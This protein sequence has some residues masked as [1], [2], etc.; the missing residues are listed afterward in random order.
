[1]IEKDGK[2]FGR[3]AC[4]MKGFLAVALALTP[5]FHSLKRSKPI[6]FAFSYDEEVGCTGVPVLTNHLID[7]GFRAD[8]CLIGEPTD[9]KVYIASKGMGI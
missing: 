6:H 8:C 3:G 5:T 1:M 9:M 2:L 4:D 7:K